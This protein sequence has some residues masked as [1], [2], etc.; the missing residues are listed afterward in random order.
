MAHHCRR[1]RR[2]GLLFLAGSRLPTKGEGLNVE[3]RSSWKEVAVGGMV[4]PS[5][6]PRDVKSKRAALFSLLST[7]NS[8]DQTLR[9]GF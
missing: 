5:A 2:R 1:R 3:E 9:G 7:S 6:F 8:I 4:C